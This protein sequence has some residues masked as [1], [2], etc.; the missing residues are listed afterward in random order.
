MHP[1]AEAISLLMR[2]ANEL[3]DIDPVAMKRIAKLVHDLELEAKSHRKRGKRVKLA[4]TGEVI[5][6]DADKLEGL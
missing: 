4:R 5:V 1:H 3:R 2:V 6:I